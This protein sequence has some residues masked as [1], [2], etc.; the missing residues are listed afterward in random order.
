MKAALLWIADAPVSLNWIQD[1]LGRTA[2]ESLCWN[3]RPFVLTAQWK[4][5][6][7]CSWVRFQETSRW[8]KYV[9]LSMVYLSSSCLFIY[10]YVYLSLYLYLSINLSILYPCI[11]HLSLPIYYLSTIYLSSIYLLSIYYLSIYYLSSIYHL[12]HLCSHP[13]KEVAFSW[14]LS[15]ITPLAAS[16]PCSCSGLSCTHSSML[17]PLNHTIIEI[18]QS[19]PKFPNLWYESICSGFLETEGL[20]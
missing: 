16:P 10:L 4:Q 8:Y 12:Q 2:E 15:C 6:T 13:S 14:P 20:C 19:R 9:D 18:P 7:R 3:R 17:L 11:C 1:R 5:S